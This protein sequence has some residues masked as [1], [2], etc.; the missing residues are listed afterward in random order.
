MAYDFVIKRNYQYKEGFDLLLTLVYMNQQFID[1][2]Y[3]CSTPS[4]TTYPHPLLKFDSPR[5]VSL[6]SFWEFLQLPSLA[7]FRKVISPANVLGYAFLCTTIF[8]HV[9]ICYAKYDIIKSK[10]Q[11]SFCKVLLLLMQRYYEK[12]KTS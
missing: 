7:N 5:L 8:K 6:P 9:L 4:L 12:I 10:F 11:N 3:I 1:H 2:N